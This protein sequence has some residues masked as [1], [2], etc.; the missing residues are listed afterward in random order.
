MLSLREQWQTRHGSMPDDG[1]VDAI[2]DCFEPL[3]SAIAAELATLVPG[4]LDTIKLLRER[5]LCIATTIGYTRAIMQA[6]IPEVKRE[7]FVPDALVC[8]DGVA[9]GRPS[10][11]GCGSVCMHCLRHHTNLTRR[12]QPAIRR[13]EKSRNFATLPGSWRVE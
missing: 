6:V 11:G 3:A 2:H 4:A 8:S 1:V 10:P 5:G 13:I 9:E 12:H 7:G